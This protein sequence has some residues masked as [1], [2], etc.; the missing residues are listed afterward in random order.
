MDIPN[1]VPIL[2]LVT[3]LIFIVFALINKREVEERLQ[4]KDAPKSTLAKDGPSKG[5]PVDV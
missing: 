1:I 4:D 3:M 2:A 5:T